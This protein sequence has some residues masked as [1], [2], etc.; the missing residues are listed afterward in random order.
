MMIIMNFIKIFGYAIGFGVATFAVMKNQ[1]AHTYK[2]ILVKYFIIIN[3]VN[4]K[5]GLN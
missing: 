4:Y 5:S 2:C 3:F 1:F